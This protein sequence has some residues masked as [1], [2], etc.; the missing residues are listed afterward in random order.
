MSS[1][2]LEILRVVHAWPTHGQTALRDFLPG[3]PLL[4]LD[5]HVLMVR[6]PGWGLGWGQ[7]R[8]ARWPPLA[9]SV[10]LPT[11]TSCVRGYLFQGQNLAK[12]PE[13]PSKTLAA[14]KKTSGLSNTPHSNLSCLCS[15][16]ALPGCPR[17]PAPVPRAEGETNESPGDWRRLQER[18]SRPAAGH[19]APVGRGVPNLRGHRSK[20]LRRWERVRWHIWEQ[21]SKQRHQHTYGPQGQRMPG[22]SEGLQEGQCGWGRARGAR[23]EGSLGHCKDSELNFL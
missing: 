2:K 1:R 5:A 13:D 8:F 21:G 22:V 12:G 11:D 19:T 10:H 15:S 3:D 17:V 14:T 20:A 6:G 4:W 18:T 9:G 23:G 16:P 7:I